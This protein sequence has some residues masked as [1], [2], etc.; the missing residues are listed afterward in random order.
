[1]L[2]VQITIV[3]RLDYNVSMIEKFNR[4]VE[5]PDEVVNLE[6]YEIDLHALEPG[7]SRSFQ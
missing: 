4:V 6:Q 5:L 1:M 2:M 7:H 3:C